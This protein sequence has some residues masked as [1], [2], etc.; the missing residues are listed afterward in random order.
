MRVTCLPV[1][2]LYARN[3]KCPGERSLIVSLMDTNEGKH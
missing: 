2:A 3:S 1:A